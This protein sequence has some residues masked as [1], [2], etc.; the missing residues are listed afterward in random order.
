MNSPCL[1]SA[2]ENDRLLCDSTEG[3]L[4]GVRIL[5]LDDSEDMTDMLGRLLQMDGANVRTAHNGAKGLELARTFEFDVILSDIS[6]PEMNGFQFLQALRALP[7]RSEVPV[8]ALTGFAMPEEIE[9]VEREGFWCQI[10]K[11]IDVEEVVQF[12]VSLTRK[13]TAA[14]GQP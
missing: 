14:T 8:V 1:G 6:M 7:N 10:S 5:I 13:R 2:D 12:V 3:V 11:P 9:R 4:R